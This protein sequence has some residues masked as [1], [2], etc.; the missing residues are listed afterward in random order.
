MPYYE[1]LF[2]LL[3]ERIAAGEIGSDERLPSE[4]S[5]C[6]GFGLSRATVRQALTKLESEGFA[7]RVAG[8]GV[9]AS[10]PQE[11]SG[12]TVQDPQGF[13]ELQLRQGKSEV[14][15]KVVGA[16]FVVPPHHVADALRL[17][18]DEEVFALERV[19][20]IRGKRAMFSTNWFPNEIGRM[21][22][23][24]QDVLD[25]SGSVNVTLG[26][27]GY[28]TERGRRIL[29]AL[30]APQRIA[31]HLGVSAAHSLLRVRS[32][33]WDQDETAFDYYETWVLTDVVPLEI[34]VAAK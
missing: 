4:Q 8:R 31:K 13:L 26:R 34:H 11:S 2:T 20:S 24:A 12:W 19:R 7:R 17:A 30:G 23:A 16:H 5:L 22:A 1:Q 18:A 15:T 33:S 6:R 28:T 9:F 21:M 29:E 14:T 3:R 10:M 25:G 32:L 27:A